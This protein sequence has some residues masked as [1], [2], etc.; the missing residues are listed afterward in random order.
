MN[1][2][3]GRDGSTAMGR[4]RSLSTGAQAGFSG[5]LWGPL[6]YVL[7]VRFEGYADHDAGRGRRGIRGLSGASSADGPHV[8][9]WGVSAV[10]RPSKVLGLEL[11]YSGATNEIENGHKYLHH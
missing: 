1:G 7:R 4:G 8:G 11:G 2:S 3:G 9:S 5:D 10:L 6:G